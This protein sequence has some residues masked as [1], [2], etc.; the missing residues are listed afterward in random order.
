MCLGCRLCKQRCVLCIR[1][2]G[3]SIAV[4]RKQSSCDTH[5]YGQVC[6]QDGA[7]NPEMN[8]HL[9]RTVQDPQARCVK[10]KGRF[11]SCPDTR[12]F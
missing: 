2:L 10:I 5:V 4:E 11:E 3:F 1:R 9:R 6:A 7:R 8:V 12:Q